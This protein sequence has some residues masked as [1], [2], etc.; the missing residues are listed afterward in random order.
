LVEALLTPRRLDVV[1]DDG[2]G[3]SLA[4]LIATTTPTRWNL[5]Q[6]DYAR[7]SLSS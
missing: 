3:L 5:P 7:S 6:L 1:T 2:A 4:M